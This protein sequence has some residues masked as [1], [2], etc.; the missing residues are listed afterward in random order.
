MQVFKNLPSRDLYLDVF[1]QLPGRFGIQVID[2]YQTADPLI[3]PDRFEESDHCVAADANFSQASKRIDFLPFA[4][5]L[6][7]DNPFDTDWIRFRLSASGTDNAPQLI[8]IRTQA[9]PFGA[10]DSSDI[11]LSIGRFTDLPPLGSHDWDSHV[12]ELGSS[13]RMSLELAPGDYYLLIADGAGV[14]TRYELCIGQ[15]VTC[16]MAPGQ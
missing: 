2:G 10:S 12:D 5:T 14:P 11:H 7:I 16:Q 6:T 13:E 4:D 15:G 9:R 8:T 3:Q 1:G